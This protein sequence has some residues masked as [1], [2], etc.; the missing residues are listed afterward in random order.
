MSARVGLFTYCSPRNT[1][2]GVRFSGARPG[3]GG[4]SVGA[5]EFAFFAR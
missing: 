1:L 3:S 4:H 2:L 5:S